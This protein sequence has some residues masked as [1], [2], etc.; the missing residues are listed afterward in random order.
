[1]QPS[2]V[3]PARLT[4]RAFGEH[5]ADELFSLHRGMPWT[6]WQLVA[7]PGATLRAYVDWRDPRVTR[8]VRYFLVALALLGATAWLADLG[9]KTEQGFDAAYR[10]SEGPALAPPPSA[11]ALRL[12]FDLLARPVVIALLTLLPAFAA[13]IE[14]VFRTSG[15]NLA[16]SYAISTFVISQVAAM[17][18]LL[19]ALGEVMPSELLVLEVV[20]LALI[21]V[22]PI[23]AI[24]GYFRDERR[25]AARAVLVFVVALFLSCLAGA[26]MIAVREMLR[27]L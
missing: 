24:R 21:L 4:V 14:R 23:G 13:A 11:P 26:M 15:I 2:R 6:F 5:I 7:N 27:R 3:R 17:L 12:A 19:M 20:L 1:M 16:E 8:P 9:V 22:Y 25:A 10:A 18:A